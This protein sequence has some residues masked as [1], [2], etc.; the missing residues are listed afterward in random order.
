LAADAPEQS[1]DQHRLQWRWRRFNAVDYVLTGLAGA[2]YFYIEFGTTGP[3]RGG[4]RGGILFDEAF[5]EA[6]V[7]NTRD[8][9][10]RGGRW[11]DALTIGPQVLAF[12][13]PLI[14]PI[15][16]DKGNTDAAWQMTAINLQ[17][18][19]ITGLIT[20]AGH[21]LVARERP[22][23]QP[24]LQ[25]PEYHRLCLAG[26]TAS[27]PSGHSSAA[28]MGAG[29]VCSH[30]LMTGLYGLPAADVG[31]CVMSMGLASSSSLLRMTADRH[32]VSDVIAGTVLGLGMG[33][34]VP[35]FVHYQPP[36]SASTDTKQ[37][38]V[39]EWLITPVAGDG[40]WGVSAAASF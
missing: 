30:H 25:D 32:W 2:A 40:V 15:F 9:R 19:A 36:R 11:S 35:L 12:A 27:F 14:I 20:R 34:A 33:L 16:F 8:G 21:R 3:S 29:L 4:W 28:F 38:R 6:I 24:C 5:R 26:A 17:A 18:I 23:V 39:F 1:E 31:V 13:E 22:D 7:A 37:S 10:E